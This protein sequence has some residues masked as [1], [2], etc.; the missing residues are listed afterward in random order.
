[1]TLDVELRHRAGAF[2]LDVAFRSSGQLT[3]LFGPSGSGKTTI[4]NLIAGLI[5]PDEGRI[6]IGGR[7]LVDTARGVFVPAHRR[8]V[9]YVFQDARL[10][11]HLSVRSNL[12]YGRWFVP[13]A[14]RGVDFARIVDLLGIGD[15]LDRR[16]QGLSG[17][18]KQRVAIG[19][20]LLASP[21]ILLMDEPLASLDEARKAEILP[22]IERLRDGMRLPIVHVSHSVAEV[23]RLATEVVVLRE[24]RVQASGATADI[25]SRA[26]LLGAERGEAGS[27]IAATVVGHDDAFGMTLLSSRAGEA[28]V[29]RIDARAGDVLRL[30]IRS[31]DV[32]LAT[33][34]PRSI[35][36]L[37]IFEGSVREIGHAD[38][39]A[40]DVVVDCGGETIVSRITRLSLAALSLAPGEAVFAVVK[41]IALDEA[42]VF[43]DGSSVGERPV[44]QSG[45]QTS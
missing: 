5:R 27:V 6:S 13:R 21:S 12:A 34:R 22:Y 39:P 19:R 14:E 30:R 2:A 23:A 37:N 38:G 45:G 7:V 31:R 41:T 43:G 9:G 35:S 25:F 4:I 1:M 15:L 36:A 44:L 8:R 42:G 29:P 40:V 18:E 3:A 11:P 32:M 33:E 16:P 20:A 24:G 17:G 10:F 26:D 28:R